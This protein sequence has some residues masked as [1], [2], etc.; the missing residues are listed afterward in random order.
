MNT[1]GET[2]IA[3]HWFLLIFCFKVLQI[4]RFMKRSAQS[5]NMNPEQ[6]TVKTSL[7]VF[8]IDED[9]YVV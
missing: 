3:P 5:P 1:P 2:K 9:I 7:E 4:P 8:M 6:K